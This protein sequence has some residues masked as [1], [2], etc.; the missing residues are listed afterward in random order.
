M[1]LTAEDF[2]KFLEDF[3][4]FLEDF[5]NRHLARP[6]FLGFEGRRRQLPEDV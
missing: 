5:V 3:V 1:P 2:V 6:N 4:D